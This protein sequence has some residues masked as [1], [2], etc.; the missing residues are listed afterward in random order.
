MNMDMTINW[1]PDHMNVAT[2]IAKERFAMNSI[3]GHFAPL[4]IIDKKARTVSD[5]RF[6]YKDRI[7][8]DNETLSL[9]EPFA[10]C[11]FTL[12]QVNE[13]GSMTGEI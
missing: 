10:R 3:A 7:V 1:D 11:N 8:V 9:Y 2:K 4:S 5:N 13:F 6:D 12:A